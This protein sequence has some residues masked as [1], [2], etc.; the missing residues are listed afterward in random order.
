MFYRQEIERIKYV[1]NDI[2]KR[3]ADALHDFDK[4]KGVDWAIAT[5]KDQITYFEQKIKKLTII[6]DSQSKG[7]SFIDPLRFK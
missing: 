2:S 6:L 3:G 4:P 1:L 5:L 7:G